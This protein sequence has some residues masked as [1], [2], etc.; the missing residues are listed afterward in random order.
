MIKTLKSKEDFVCMEG[1]SEEQIKEAERELGLTFS[2]DYKEYLAMF[3]AA[4]ANGH[5]FTGIIKSQ[6]LNVV[7]VTKNARD[8]NVFVPEDLYVLEEMNLDRIIIW[9]NYKGELFQTIG[10][11]EPEK[12]DCSFDEFLG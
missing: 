12:L 11:S 9:Q 1:A 2:E 7:D 3:G 4:C 8:N 6:R 5:E 10:T